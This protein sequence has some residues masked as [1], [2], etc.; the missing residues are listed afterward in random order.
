M[1]LPIIVQ[2][3][4]HSPT[5]EDRGLE[6]LKDEHTMLGFL[7][8]RLKACCTEDVVLATSV[9]PKDDSLIREAK[10]YEVQTVRGEMSNLVSRLLTA[11]DAIKAERFV[12]VLGNYPLVDAE[13]LL[14]LVDAHMERGADYSYNEYLGGVP[15][16][17]GCEVIKTD[18]LRQLEGQKLTE[19]QQAVATL[20]MR[21]HPEL[22]IIHADALTIERNGYKVLVETR[23]DLELVRDIV[24][25]VDDITSRSVASYLDEH[26]VLARSNME[27][28]V[29]EVGIEKLYLHPAKLEGLHGVEK[30]VPDPTFPISVE[31]S[32]TNKCNL[33]C[34]WCSDQDL[35]SRQGFS[36]ELT[37]DE[38]NTLFGE[39]K[40]GGTRGVVI[41]GGGEPTMHPEFEE[42][43]ADLAKA[44]LP[45]GLI[46][47]GTQPLSPET[48]A[49]FDWIRVSLDASTPEE[50]CRF[51]GRDYYERVL[52]NIAFYARYCPT[53]GVGYVVTHDNLGDMESLIL[54]IREYGV[55]YIQMR[56]VVDAPELSPGLMDLSH[57]MRYQ[58]KD[59]S[60]II[61]GM[62]DNAVKG[63][64]CLPCKTHSISS[65]IC[66]DGSVFLCG[67]MNVY[68]WL[69]P[70]GNL[71]NAS[72]GEIWEGDKRRQQHAMVFD[73][74]FCSKHCPACRITAFNRL[75]G[76]LDKIRTPNFI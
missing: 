31:L 63:N 14:R 42:V 52:D 16:G 4:N 65:V 67:R 36:S 6:I 37:R 5:F 7:L 71:R 18:A 27:E 45:A 40:T 56:P 69:E 73:A 21:Q 54:R 3:T 41:E 51:K 11:A 39:L 60:V 46:T 2:C 17:M 49:R 47:N 12:R 35:R 75:F 48:C 32:L 70:I 20:Y 1:D 29:P 23:A 33:R 64:A 22:F 57:L 34:V 59:F 19:N 53:V 8:Q 55:R 15:L 72:F 66:A 25:H 28:S 44:G 68:D 61:A 50:F 43:I 26:P 74:G 30:G 62:K 24:R 10:K 38:L 58:G 13:A 76:R 9:S